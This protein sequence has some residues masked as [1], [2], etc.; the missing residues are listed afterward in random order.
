MRLHRNTLKKYHG[1]LYIAPWL[2][3]FFLLTLNPFITSFVYSFTNF[4]M[5]HFK[6]V[7]LQ[8]YIDI[9]TKDEIFTGSLVR[10]LLYTGISVPAK[11]FVAL[12]L[13]VLLNKKIKGIG[14]FRTLFYL[15][16]ILGASVALAILWKYLFKTDGLVNM[17]LAVLNLP[18]VNWLGDPD[19]AL[20]CLILLPLWQMGSPM[21]LFLAALKTVPGEIVEAATIDGAGK[22]RIFMHVTLPMITSVIFFNLIMQ[23]IEIIQLFTPAYI[24][25]QG[26]PIKAT[27]LYALMLYDVSFRDFKMGYASALSWI[28]FII[29]I[30][31]TVI[32]FRTSRKW[33]YYSDGGD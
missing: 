27:Y 26:G 14:V 20:I 28:L 24:I 2:A 4:D 17:F 18:S 6:F 30:T 29:V 16:S 1:Y 3:G 7:G 32:L 22:V 21:V 19:N 33:V 12:M 23:T 5:F 11:L 13:A 9:F 25:T 10:T 15:P 31:Y 8:N